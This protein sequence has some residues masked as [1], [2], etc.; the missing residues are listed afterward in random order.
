MPEGHT[1]HRLAR[2]HRRL[3]GGKQLRVSSPQGRFT[4]ADVVDRRKLREVEP[5]GKHLFYHFTTGTVHVHLGMYG[6]FAYRE[7]KRG[8]APPDPTPTTRMRLVSAARCVDLTGPTACHLVDDDEYQAIHGRIGPDLL[9]PDADRDAV[10]ERVLKMDRPIG[11]VL[12][13]QSI[14]SGIGNAYRSELLLRQGIHPRS[15]TTALTA[16]RFDAMWDDA[17]HL[18]NL[19]VKHSHMFCVDPADV[20]KVKVSEL[21]RDERF[22]VY[23]RE[24]CRKCGGPVEQFEMAGRRVY[25]CPRD[26][27]IL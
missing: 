15:R 10:R 19:G 12:M 2:Y 25:A 21:T 22:Y 13:D 9:R 11:V 16:E 20:G 8:Q 1:I 7:K 17:V 26:Q 18:L 24:T 3:L 6:K 27:A 5:L 23:R 4:E 14:L